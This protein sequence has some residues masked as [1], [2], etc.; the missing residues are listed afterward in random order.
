M[1]FE[2]GGDGAEVFELVE[3]AFDQVVIT[4]KQG[5]QQGPLLYS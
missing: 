1:L 5:H 3:E 2:A 4:P